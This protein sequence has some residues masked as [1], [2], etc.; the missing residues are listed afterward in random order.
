MQLLK[1]TFSAFSCD[2][3]PTLAAAL[4][5]YAAFALPPLLYLLLTVL[6]LGLS[7]TYSSDEAEDKARSTIES[8]AAALIGN[9]EVSDEIGSMLRNTQQSGGAWWKILLSF[10][11]IV[12]GATGVV[13]ALQASLNRVWQVQPNPN[14]NSLA[15]VVRKRLL[16]LAMILGLALLLFLSLVAST[17]LRAIGDQAGE[18]LGMPGIAAE[19]INL[20]VQTGMLLVVFAGLFKFMPDAKVRWSDVGFG[21]ALTTLLFLLGRYAMQWYFQLA[22][23]GAQLGAAAASL[24]V[25]LVWVYYTA[26][27]VLLGAEATRVWAVLYGKG[28]EP[29][30]G[31][32]RIEIKQIPTTENN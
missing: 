11:G 25:L 21:A 20:A 14:R 10:A 23:P 5:Y 15:D 19:G 13:A 12:L 7:T 3:C 32:V 18:W 24:A 9:P 27:I 8:Q 1:R 2:D 6:T 28:I 22:N 31:A 4:A 17:V 29:E 30:A 26:M 16:S